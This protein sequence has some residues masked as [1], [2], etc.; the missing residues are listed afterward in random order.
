MCKEFRQTAASEHYSLR[1]FILPCPPNLPVL[2]RRD[3]DD[4]EIPFNT[5]LC[6]IEEKQWV[7]GNKTA[8]DVS[9]GRRRWN[10]WREEKLYV[11]IDLSN[12][13]FS[14]A[15]LGNTDLTVAPK[16]PQPPREYRHDNRVT[17]T[18][19]PYHGVTREV[20]A[21]S[22]SG[23]NESRTDGPQTPRASSWPKTK[24]HRDTK[25]GGA[26]AAQCRRAYGE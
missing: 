2:A 17:Q 16:A 7:M 26:N 19:L 12:A 9:G 23:V 21:Q 11:I 20:R 5:A 1:A 13:D 24:L 14:G 8:C 3:C 6:V 25:E 18:L 10:A 22:N 15:D 4:E